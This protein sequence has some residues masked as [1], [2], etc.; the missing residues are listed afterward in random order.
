MPVKILNHRVGGLSRH[1]GG[2]SNLI[3]GPLNIGLVI[4]S[5]SQIASAR[6]ASLKGECKIK[7]RSGIVSRGTRSSLFPERNGY[8]MLI[9]RLESCLECRSRRY[10]LFVGNQPLY[11]WITVT[12]LFDSCGYANF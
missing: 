6:L 11:Q 1:E 7:N 9:R 2:Y 5:I 10:S 4:V 3:R 12:T 8:P